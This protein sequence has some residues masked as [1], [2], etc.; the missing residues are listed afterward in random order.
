MAYSSTLSTRMWNCS[1]VSCSTVLLGNFLNIGC[2]LYDS[3]LPS[4]SVPPAQD[5]FLEKVSYNAR[6]ACSHPTCLNPIP[7]A[8][9][10]VGRPSIAFPCGSLPL[11]LPL[12]LSPG[13]RFRGR[14]RGRASLTAFGDLRRW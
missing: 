1:A 6:A 3:N 4:D 10:L 11:P 7:V 8:T 14:G 12:L 5:N 13:R 2:D 9:A